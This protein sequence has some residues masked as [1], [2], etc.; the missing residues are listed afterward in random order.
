[1]SLVDAL[2]SV[3]A[4]FNATSAVLMLSAW[5]AIKRGRRDLHWRLMV[6]ALAASTLFLVGYLTRTAL[7]G[8]H[9][10]EG[11]PWLRGLYLVIL[12]SHMLLAMAVVPLVLRA[13]YLGARGRYGKHKR[14]VRWAL[15]IWAYVS[16]TGV[17]VYVMLYHVSDAATVS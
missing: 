3:N 11:E 10:F 4:A 15:P 6:G 14:V 16:I 12:F 1:M 8:T 13:V 17:V 2:P 5:R 9:K 7:T